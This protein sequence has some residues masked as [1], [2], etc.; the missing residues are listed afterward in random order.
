MTQPRSKKSPEEIE[1]AVSQL[2]S[3][4]PAYKALLD[5][6]GNVF[7]AQAT[8]T[9]EIE[10][11]P[12]AGDLLSARR[13]EGLPLIDKTEFRIDL[14]AARRLFDALC[15]AAVLP[16]GGLS[17]D[18]GPLKKVVADGDIDPENLFRAVLNDDEAAFADAARKTGLE[19][20]VIEFFAYNSIKPSLTVCR[21]HLSPHLDATGD[22]DKGYCPVCGGLPVLSALSIDAGARRLFC[23]VCWHDWSAPRM[24]CPYCD[25]AEPKHH[26][27]LHTT[28]EPEYRVD[29]C[30][31]CRSYMK[32]VDLRQLPRPFHPPLEALAT[33]HLD[34][35]AR[36]KGYRSGMSPDIDP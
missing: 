25:H 36:E 29:L 1:T 20:A 26:P 35:T 27:Y 11:I 12:I 34:M 9:P 6:Y 8:S 21:D 4:R 3:T 16:E 17:V 14:A 22:W 13:Q 28:E 10:P 31:N 7:I 5:F 32:T 2:K 24:R 23:A 30:E 33:L 15:D 19:S 18:A